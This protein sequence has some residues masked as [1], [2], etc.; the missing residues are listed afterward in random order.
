MTHKKRF[1]EIKQSL[2]T[3]G[4]REDQFVKVELLFFEAINISRTY[5][6]NAAENNLLSA[7]KETQ[8]DQ[9]E[10]TKV[11]TK[12]PKQREILIRKFV[13]RLKQII[14]ARI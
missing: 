10:K 4:Y 7:L 5:G 9:Y 14:G 2:Q 8:Y 6:D 1:S 12:K 3:L 11:F 13:L